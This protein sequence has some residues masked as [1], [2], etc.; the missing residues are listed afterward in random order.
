M[1]Y[2][3]PLLDAPATVSDDAGLGALETPRGC[4]PLRSLDVRGRV[5]GLLAH[6][7]V[8]Q[9]FRNPFDEP[10]EA[11]Y[12]F[13]LPDRAA[14]TRFRLTAADRVIEG[15]LK[16]R[17]Q[18][19]D[20]YDQA[21]QQGHRAA[22]AEEERSGVFTM[23]VGNIP[24]H[25]EAAVELEL[26]GPLEVSEDEATYRFPI[27]VAPRYTPGVPL[28]GP[29][30]GDGATPD[31]DQVPDASRV[32]PPVLLPGFPNPV[33]LSLEVELDPAGPETG[34]PRLSASLHSVVVN[35]QGPPWTVRLTPGERLNRDFILRFPVAANEV[36]T[37]LQVSPAAKD[38]PGVFALT[39]TP[40][41]MAVARPKPREVVFVLDRSGSMSGWKMVAA[42]RALGRMIDTLLDQ[43]RFTVIAFDD[44][45]ETPSSDAMRSGANRD[46]WRTL[47]W[48]AAIEAR[49][50]TEM[51]PALRAALRCF[52]SKGDEIDRV[53][54]VVT[55]GQVT[56]EDA[57]LRTMKKESA[58]AMPRV[59]TLGIDRAVNAGFLRRLAELGGGACDLVESEDRLDEALEGVH[60]LI[61]QP[62]LTDVELELLDFDGVVE[63]LAPSRLAGLYAGRPLMIF[64][65]HL[66]ERSDVRIRIRARNAA[67]E[68]WTSTVSGRAGPDRVLLNL[69]GRA[70]VRELE[71]RYAAG[72]MRDEP[73]A[74]R[75][76]KLS[77]ETNVLCRFT[78][79]VAVDKSE[80]VNEG[81]RQHRVI[82]P[83]ESPAGWEGA[84]AMRAMFA[85]P[86]AF[87]SRSGMPR[88]RARMSKWFGMNEPVASVDSMLQEFV[89]EDMDEAV[90]E[91]SVPP[92]REER[93]G[94]EVAEVRRIVE[95]MKGL[96][97]LPKRKD[98]AHLVRK[99]K[100]L[101]MTLSAGGDP[102]HVDVEK[103]VEDGDRLL[104]GSWKVAGDADLAQRLTAFLDAIADCLAGFEA[105]PSGKREA[106]WKQPGDAT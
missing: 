87:A 79:Y 44:R 86:A 50:G 37:S 70:K 68:P 84:P 52:S 10:L 38:K 96:G 95:R 22:I 66:S 74:E 72:G 7:T 78:A 94:N 43:D 11:T 54:V 14:V 16:E 97:G 60:R 61:G 76:T 39:L 28:D 67:G 71:D 49:G 55:D 51:G 75:I 90:P 92:T 9:T 30:V 23:R 27:V 104:R 91:I 89:A 1:T 98:V 105:E 21:I 47:E 77:L 17:G 40:P 36:C 59:F 69:W 24:P 48:L 85:A 57:L 3:L 101:A 33:H 99:L 82:Q 31:T 4:L 80:V 41:A 56:G 12:I 100:G 102:K 2:A 73:L 58:G 25:E 106:F 29:P 53:L 46:R 32:T 81:G 19:R 15:E 42:R 20:E 88:G 34:R 65:R 8:R 45:I 6:T 13:P 26:V 93:P 63:T 64:G 83:V 5:S 18:A 35:E 103:L 62:V